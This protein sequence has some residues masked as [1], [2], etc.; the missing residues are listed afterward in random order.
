MPRA[1]AMKLLETPP[2]PDAQQEEQDRTFVM[3]KLGFTEASF[4]E[5]MAA[6][7]VA[8]EVYGSE[9]WLWDLLA[10]AYRAARR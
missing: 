7:A 9:T 2:Y 10:W 6:P 3:K 4:R 1:D 5:Y 8:H